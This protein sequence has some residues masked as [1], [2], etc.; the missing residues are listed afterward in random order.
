MKYIEGQS[1]QI[2]LIH[3]YCLSSWIFLILIYKMNEVNLV[4]YF[5]HKLILET[6]IK[7]S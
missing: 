6:I 4:Y 1:S 3:K 2:K 7:A 5:I